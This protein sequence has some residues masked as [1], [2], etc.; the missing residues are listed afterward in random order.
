MFVRAD[1]YST[2]FDSWSATRICAQMD[3]PSQIV[4]DLYLYGLA[5]DKLFAR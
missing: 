3:L 2:A 4:L 5:P 1:S